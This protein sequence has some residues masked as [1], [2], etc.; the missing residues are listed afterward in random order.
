MYIQGDFARHLESPFKGGNAAE[1]HPNEENSVYERAQQ[2]TYKYVAGERKLGYHKKGMISHNLYE[3]TG[4]HHCVF[5][6]GQNYFH[7]IMVKNK[8]GCFLLTLIVNL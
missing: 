6:I 2:Y 5:P 1:I 4:K 8:R 7:N 3:T